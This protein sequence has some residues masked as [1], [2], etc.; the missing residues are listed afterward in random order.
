MSDLVPA[1]GCA[2][3]QRPL[4]NA[5]ARQVDNTLDLAASAGS[6]IYFVGLAS[7]FREVRVY[8]G[9]D[10]D[11]AFAPAS[12]DAIYVEQGRRL[13]I[14]E[15]NLE[16]LRRLVAAGVDF[17]EVFLAH[18][19]PSGWVDALPSGPTT[20]DLVP[21]RGMQLIT[22]EQ[23]RQVVRQ[24]GP[25]ASTLRLAHRYGQVSKGLLAA[26]A[27]MGVAAGA[28]VAIAAAPLMLLGTAG[29]GQTAEVVGI[30]PILLGAAPVE[31]PAFPGE[32]AWF[33][34]T[35]WNY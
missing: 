26:Y 32:S 10:R 5:V 27:V 4:P 31:G 1:G 34:L 28:V 23:A 3:A 8:R 21:T 14:P 22:P 2:M 15:E 30:D 33:V 16:G 6:T 13:P 9:V 25:H 29:G 35:E 11:W 24:P 12:L 18:D 7:V 17:P 20:T 19:I